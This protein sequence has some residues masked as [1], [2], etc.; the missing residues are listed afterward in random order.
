V[1]PTEPAKRRRRPRKITPDSYARKPFHP[2][3]KARDKIKRERS[4]Q[5]LKEG[6]RPR[7]AY[8][9][10]S[11]SS[12]DAGRCDSVSASRLEAAQHVSLPLRAARKRLGRIPG[13]SNEAFRGSQ[14]G[15]WLAAQITV[16]SRAPVW[17]PLIH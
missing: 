15:Q 3:L 9:Y 7:T 11:G 16:L 14:C 8:H 4:R 5:P 10:P 17:K 13:N 12:L 1:E 6:V 2:S